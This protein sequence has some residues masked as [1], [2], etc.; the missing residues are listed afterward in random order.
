MGFAIGQVPGGPPFKDPERS[1]AIIRYAIERGVNF[2]DLGTIDYFNRSEYQSLLKLIRLALQNGY[3][4]HI[5]YSFSIPTM[6]VNSVADYEPMLANAQDLLHEDKVDFLV[7][8]GI[9]RHSWQKMQYMGVLPWLG[10]KVADGCIGHPGFSF[11]D[12]FQTLRTVLQDYRNWTLCKFRLSFMD[13]DQYP[14]LGGVQLAADSGLA[15]IADQP[16]L[17]GR[18]IK[19]LPPSVSACWSTAGG[20]WTAADWGLRW[21]WNN[22]QVAT[23]VVNMR[24]MAHVMQA[25]VLVEKYAGRSLTI[26]EEIN[27]SR[28]RDEYRKLRAVPCTGC[29]SCLPCLQNIDIP[30][31]FTL[32]NEAVMFQD[33]S[34][35]RAYFKIEGHEPDACDGCGICADKCGMKISIP[36]Q[37]RAARQA[38]G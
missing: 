18:L 3:R 7:L 29:R 17:N 25:D 22:P 24:T 32:W 16:L 4:Q 27:I 36:E 21:V 33:D 14:G 35:P 1:V 26:P 11:H 31:I 15:V 9:D 5:K 10:K 30:R 12:D 34:I 13:A 2:L 38:I 20:A 28:V 23:T 8:D 37:I 19:N 6:H